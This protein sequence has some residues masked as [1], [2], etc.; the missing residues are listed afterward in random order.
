MANED[1]PSNNN[2]TAIRKLID[3]WAT[4]VQAKDI[5]RIMACYAP[6]VVAYDLPPPLQFKGADAYRKDWEA[7]LPMMTDGM[8]FEM[9]D[10]TVVADDKLGFAHYLS[11]F[12]GKEADG[13]DIDVW[14]RAT[15]CYRKIG[16]K[17]LVVHEHMSVP[18]DM[19]ENKALFDVKP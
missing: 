8:R 2:E 14:A 16:G 12:T 5:S 4:A 10:L 6:E 3:D 11:H 19:D 17:W 1:T 15:D 9:R 7:Y 18:I 13:K